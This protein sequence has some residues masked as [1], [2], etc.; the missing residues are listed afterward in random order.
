MPGQR[1]RPGQPLRPSFAG[2][3]LGIAAA[4]VLIA[5]IIVGYF[6]LSEASLLRDDDTSPDDLADSVAAV[7]EDETEPTF[8]LDDSDLA[9]ADD[10][11]LQTEEP[12]PAEDD[13]SAP[14]SAEAEA[15]GQSEPQPYIVVPGDTL[16][17][18]AVRHSTSIAALAGYNG[19][20]D[21]NRLDV[22]QRIQIPPADYVPPP[23]PDPD[24]PDTAEPVP[25]PLPPGPTG[26]PPQ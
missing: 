19:I 5:P 8:I 17:S 4:G 12:R 26:A 14:P 1:K 21:I 11:A 6:L 24:D 10:V 23:L 20:E 25:V 7:S 16:A 2:W 9:L 3:R 18:I 15:D 22:G 13:A